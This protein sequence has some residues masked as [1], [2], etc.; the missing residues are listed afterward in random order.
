MCDQDCLL[1]IE[2][3]DALRLV[4]HV[5][6]LVLSLLALY[7]VLPEKGQAVRSKV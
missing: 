2:L 7:Q 6:G 5:L 1:G 4:R 3:Q